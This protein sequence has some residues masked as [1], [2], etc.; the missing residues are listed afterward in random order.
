MP[1]NLAHPYS[2]FP[3]VFV[4]SNIENIPPINLIGTDEEEAKILVKEVKRYIFNS[5]PESWGKKCDP[6]GQVCIMT[7]SATQVNNKDISFHKQKH[8]SHSIQ[9]V[10]NLLR[11]SPDSCI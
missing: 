8:K 9:Q 5:W 1:D 11:P 10:N 7:P 6:P 3:L 4:C 2:P